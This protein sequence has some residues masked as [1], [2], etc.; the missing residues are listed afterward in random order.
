MDKKQKAIEELKKQTRLARERLGPEGVKQLEKL[1][2]D[3]ASKKKPKSSETVPYDKA[4]A[5]QAF[6]LFLDM[7]GNPEEF[8]RKLL[9]MIKQKS[10]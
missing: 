10:H 1:A 4:A 3:I 2:K 9:E 8:Q 6:K 5:M 7:H